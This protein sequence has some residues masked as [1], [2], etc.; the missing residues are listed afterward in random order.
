MCSSKYLGVAVLKLHSLNWNLWTLNS[1]FLSLAIIVYKSNARF[2]QGNICLVPIAYHEIWVSIVILILRLRRLPLRPWSF[3]FCFGF[4][5]RTSV[6][7]AKLNIAEGDR[8][9]SKSWNSRSLSK[10]PIVF[11]FSA[12]LL[13]KPFVVRTSR[14]PFDFHS[15]PGKHFWTCF[16]KNGPRAVTKIEVK[17][18]RPNELLKTNWKKHFVPFCGGGRVK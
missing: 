1:I 16:E 15:L 14:K 8:K 12:L 18:F 5:F 2:G 7:N 4:H 10:I 17:K 13:K 3:S 9:Q 11:I 6:S